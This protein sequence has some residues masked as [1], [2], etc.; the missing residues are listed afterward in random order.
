MAVLLLLASVHAGTA[1]AQTLEDA[2]R[3]YLEADFRGSAEQFAAVLHTPSV[4]RAAAVEAHRHLAALHQLLDDSDRARLHAEAAVALDPAAAPPEGAPPAVEDLFEAARESFRGRAAS[5]AIEREERGTD[6]ELGAMVDPAPEAL[7]DRIGLRCV[8]GAA[9][10][11]E[12]AELPDVR[13]T[14]AAPSQEVHCRAWIT[15]AGGAELLDASA[16]FDATSGAAPPGSG[17]AGGGG[18][19]WPWVGVGAAVAVAGA[20]V[21]YLLISSAAGDGARLGEPQAEGWE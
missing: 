18:S 4:D 9:S 15:G 21:A 16:R 10:H 7:A 14:M 17:S 11:E 1:R 5:I 13:L 12:I 8:H 19:V 6:W 20:V 2:R 3:A